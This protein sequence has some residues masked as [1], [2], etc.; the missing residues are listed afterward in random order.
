M[1]NAIA[2]IRRSTD[3]QEASLDDQRRSIADYAQKESFRLVREF[4]DDA[5]SGKTM[6]AR[7]GFKNRIEF[8]RN[9]NGE[10]Y[11]L[12]VYDVSRFGRFE[13]PKEA[14]YWEFE[15]ER[16]GIKVHYVTEDMQNDGSLGSYITKVV[17]DAEASE[18]IKKLSK[19]TKRGIKSCA[20][21]GYWTTSQAPYGYARAVIEPSTGKVEHVLKRGERRAVHGKRI[22][23]VPGD[24]ERIV[25]VREIFDRYANREQGLLSIADYLNQKGIKNPSGKNHWHKSTLRNILRNPAYIGT[26]E[27]HRRPKDGLVAT[28]NA[29]EALI[30]KAVYERAQERLNNAE[31]GKR[32][33]H[34]TPYLLTALVQ[35]EVCGNNLHGATDRAK[36][37]RGYRCSGYLCKGPSVC[38][39]PYYPA[40]LIEQP[41]IYHIKEQTSSPLWNGFVR[42]GLD[43]AVGEDQRTLEQRVVSAKTEFEQNKGK[44]TNLLEAIADGLPRETA[45]KKVREIE[46]RQETLEDTILKEE[47]KKIES[48]HYQKEAEQLYQLGLRLETTYDQ[49]TPQE[50]KKLA[51]TFLERA[52]VNHQMSEITYYFYEFPLI[53]KGKPSTVRKKTSLNRKK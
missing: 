27:F 29:H 24:E 9:S 26:V 5:I 18:Y 50:K 28:E 17:K 46:Q 16:H 8:A 32:G 13:N 11:T 3:M 34:T 21:R 48:T 52:T 40:E 43:H 39:S 22:K 35:C 41:V 20:E 36:S 7:P 47:A 45:I 14:T 31:F 6:D 19:L 30:D 38:T 2:Y 53:G 15:L 12:L 33:G 42:R 25:V 51:V 49:L 44:I 10:Q 37:R 4:C 1:G 23:L